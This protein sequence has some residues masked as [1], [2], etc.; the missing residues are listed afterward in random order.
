MKPPSGEPPTEAPDALTARRERLALGRKLALFVLLSLGFA[1]LGFCT[2]LRQ[3]CHPE[4]LQ[5]A[6]RAAGWW[7]PALLLAVGALAPLILLPRW[8]LAVVCGLLYGVVWGSLLANVAS[9]LGAWL[10]YR[11][12]HV[13]LGA[14]AGRVVSPRWRTQLADPRRV[15]VALVALRAF[16]LSNFVA[17]NLLAGSLRIPWRTY[18]AASFFGMLPSTI[19]YAAWGKVVRQPSRGFTLLVGGSL[20]LLT[21]GAWLIQRWL[22]ARPE[23]GQGEGGWRAAARRLLAA[24]PRLWVVLLFA[25]AVWGGQMVRRDLW[26]PDEARFA[27]VADE[28]RATHHWLVPQRSGEIYAHKPPLMFWLIN[29]GALVTGGRIGPVATRLPS[30]LGCVLALFGAS[31]LLAR[32]RDA[33]AAWLVLPLLAGGYLFW[34]TGSMGQIDALLLGLQMAALTLLFEGAEAAP[35]VRWRAWRP[36]AAGLLLGFAILAKGPVGLLVPLGAFLAATLAAGERARLRRLPWLLLLLLALLPPALWLLAC[37]R[38]GAPDSYF[39]ELLFAQNVSRAGGALGH[40]RGW[41]YFLWHA[42][43]D[44]L[45]WTLFLPWAWLDLGGDADARRLRR[46]LAGWALWVIFFFTLSASKRS[47]YVLLAFPAAAMLIAA[48]GERLAGRRGVV[49]LCL[50]L[51]LVLAGIVALAV[52]WPRPPPLPAALDAAALRRALALLGVVAAGWALWVARGLVGDNP[53]RARVLPAFA[54]LWVT[55]LALAGTLLLPLLNPVKTPVAL[56]AAARAHLPPGERLLIYRMNGEILALYT[57]SRG[58]HVRSLAELRLAMRQQRRGLLV[59]DR[60]QWDEIGAATALPLSA[61]AA[62]TMGKKQLYW[63][64]FDLDRNDRVPRR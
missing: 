43:M 52:G 23:T 46:R 55:L 9:L 17:T 2:P 6:A 24:P 41:S 37:Y 54:L 32:W 39:R 58:R 1:A 63:A 56:V 4:A 34:Q 51:A 25:L 45:P 40:V 28:M 53:R 13:S 14:A 21:A 26:E 18:L 16:P 36:W 7:A 57:G 29:A 19:L 64:A 61:S 22:F 33:R 47:L 12:A 35:A 62:F 48:A 11:F 30:L 20:L 27:Y 49:R 59:M 42:P 10:Q 31:R 44:F 50:G 5:Q 8:P 15:F 3:F 38:N 60:R